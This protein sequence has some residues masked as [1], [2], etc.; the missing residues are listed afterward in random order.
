MARGRPVFGSHRAEFAFVGV[1]VAVIGI[2]DEVDGDDSR[3]VRVGNR[4]GK[5]SEQEVGDELKPLPVERMEPREDGVVTWCSVG[6]VAGF[7]N[8]GLVDAGQYDDEPDVAGVEGGPST[9]GNGSGAMT[10]SATSLTSEAER[11]PSR[12]EI[13]NT[14]R[15]RHFLV[16]NSTI[17]LHQ[18]RRLKNIDLARDSLQYIDCHK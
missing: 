18:L 10:S 5:A 9:P 2:V 7:P 14:S 17:Q 8:R 1:V 13:L 16:V 6:V 4:Y 3:P 12:S 11:Y 15:S